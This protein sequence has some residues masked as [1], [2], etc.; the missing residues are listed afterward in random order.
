VTIVDAKCW[1]NFF[2]YRDI[3]RLN[4]LLRNVNEKSQNFPITGWIAMIFCLGK[5]GEVG[6]SDL[7]QFTTHARKFA[8]ELKFS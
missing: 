2:K 5:G 6:G 1:E 8:S 4:Q 3:L 7:P